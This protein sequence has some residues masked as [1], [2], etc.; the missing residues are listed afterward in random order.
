VIRLTTVLLPEWK[1]ATPY[2]PPPIDGRLRRRFP[3]AVDPPHIARRLAVQHSRFT[4][5]GTDPEGLLSLGRRPR[6]RLQKITIP[7]SAITGMRKDLSTLGIVDTSLF[8]DLEG[9]SRGLIR[10]YKSE[11]MLG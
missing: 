10:R 2:L 8:P 4:V 9:L 11:W 5:H 7:R 1:Q 6:S 3:I